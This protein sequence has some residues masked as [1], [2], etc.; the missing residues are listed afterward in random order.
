[1]SVIPMFRKQAGNVLLSLLASAAYLFF[2]LVLLTL[3]YF[4]Y[5]EARKAYWDRQVKQMCEKDGGV[6]VYEKEK[7]S[8]ELYKQLGGQQ[9][10]IPIY[11]KSSTSIDAPYFTE[12]R[13]SYLHEKDPQVRRSETRYMKMQ[14]NKTLAIYVYYAR[15]GGDFPTF[16]HPSS[17]GCL[18]P[19]DGLTKQFIQIEGETK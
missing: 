10:E 9:G 4:V 19:K 1:M 18:F 13:T 8:R 11:S 2:G 17:Q 3:A 16:A 15:V 7:I 6:R 12:E 14:N 5:C